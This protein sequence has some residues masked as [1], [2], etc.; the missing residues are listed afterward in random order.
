MVVV[1][2]LVVVSVVLV[3]VRVVAAVVVVVAVV[4]LVV[5]V[6]VTSDG[7]RQSSNNSGINP[8]VHIIKLHFERSR[9][10]LTLYSLSSVFTILEFQV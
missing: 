2:V 5:A 4:V 9:L 6:L 3:V 1:V 10:S 7:N 8:I